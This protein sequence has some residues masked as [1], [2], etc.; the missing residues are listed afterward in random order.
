MNEVG[1]I[2]Y[3][4]TINNQYNGDDNLAYVYT[5]RE[6]AEEWFNLFIQGDYHSNIGESNFDNWLI[7][8]TADETE[9]FYKDA[10]EYGA[11]IKVERW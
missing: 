7:E 4:D 10:V 11:V 8:N 2:V 1:I 6:F 9:S 3:Y 5:S